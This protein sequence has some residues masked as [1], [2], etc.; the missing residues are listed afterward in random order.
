MC[1]A[2]G[3]Q[4]DGDSGGGSSIGRSFDSKPRSHIESVLDS[5]EDV[6]EGRQGSSNDDQ[7]SRTC[8][9]SA[10]ETLASAPQSTAPTTADSSSAD[11]RQQ[12]G[13]DTSGRTN[14]F[15]SK[16]G[17]VKKS[18]TSGRGRPRRGQV[19]LRKAVAK[20]AFECT[21][22]SHGELSKVI[23]LAALERKTRH[24]G[25]D[26]SR[27]RGKKESTETRGRGRRP[28][29]KGQPAAPGLR[30]EPVRYGADIDVGYQ[31]SEGGSGDRQPRTPGA[32]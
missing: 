18:G 19:P 16:T 32:R 26:K 23:D 10:P 2:R 30:V 21:T 6:G 20:R 12:L 25:V 9:S 15:S 22:G 3:V 1:A 4:R 28:N 13:Q 11:H 17:G 5:D 27:V 8:S 7:L 31:V 29:S 24:I 14:K